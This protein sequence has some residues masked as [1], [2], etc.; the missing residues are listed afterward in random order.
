M[1]SARRTGWKQNKKLGTKAKN[2]PKKF[3]NRH[4]F[5]AFRF[6]IFNS[7]SASKRYMYVFPDPPNLN[8]D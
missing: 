8:L 1:R 6:K 3:G 2:S 5:K 7:V 4:F